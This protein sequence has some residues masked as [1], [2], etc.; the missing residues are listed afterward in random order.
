MKLRMKI[1]KLTKQLEN[2]TKDTKLHEAIASQIASLQE[3]VFAR[4]STIKADISRQ[5]ANILRKNAMRVQKMETKQAVKSSNK[6]TSFLAQNI[7]NNAKMN[8]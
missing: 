8:A 6:A 3:V 4:S 7:T 1:E 5:S 2:T